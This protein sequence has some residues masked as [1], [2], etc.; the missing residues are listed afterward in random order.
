MEK[1]LVAV[2]KQQL[3]YIGGLSD[4]SGVVFE[5]I[6]AFFLSDIS[7]FTLTNS[8]ESV[9]HISQTSRISSASDIIMINE[10]RQT[11]F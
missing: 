9:A 10:Y 3:C 8:Q 2:G 6:R 7:S 11:S 4:A 5:D 1:L